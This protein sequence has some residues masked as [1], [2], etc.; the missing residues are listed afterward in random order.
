MQETMHIAQLKAQVGSDGT[1]Y[2]KRLCQVNFL[3]TLLCIGLQELYDTTWFARAEKRFHPDWL[4]MASDE[5]H[6]PDLQQA[7]LRMQQAGYRL[8]SV[9][10]TPLATLIRIVRP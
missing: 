2:A 5:G 4:V 7:M 1:Y 9:G 6:D 10:V 8:D 3:D